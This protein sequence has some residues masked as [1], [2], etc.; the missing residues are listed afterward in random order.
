MTRLNRRDLDQALG[1]SIP[2]GWPRHVLNA[3]LDLHA[4]SDGSRISLW[5]TSSWN[6]TGGGRGQ[7]GL[8]RAAGG[9]RRGL[10]DHVIHVVGPRHL[11]VSGQ[12]GP[13]P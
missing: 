8:D 2:A 4:R 10:C 3:Q 13:Y 9:T 6:G 11:A 7:S 12:P 5:R 1:G